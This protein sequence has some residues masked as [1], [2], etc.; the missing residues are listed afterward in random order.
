MIDLTDAAAPERT[1]GSLPEQHATADE[2]HMPSPSLSP[3]ILAAG[4]TMA[5]FGIV[6]G[7]ILIV[8]GAVGILVGLGTWLYDEIVNASNDEH[9]TDGA[10]S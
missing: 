7:P 9:S 4:M 2:P 1:T 10:H 6:L 5:A 8:L 3:L